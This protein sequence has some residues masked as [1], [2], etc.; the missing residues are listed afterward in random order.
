[1]IL[2]VIARFEEKAT[3]RKVSGLISK[4]TF[5]HIQAQQ[6]WS[7]AAGAPDQA[8]DWLNIWLPC[9]T[10]PS[11]FEC[12]S[13]VIHGDLHGLIAMDLRGKRVQ[14]GDAL[15]VDFLATNPQD[16]IALRGFKYIGVS[17]MAVAVARS[18]ELGMA[19]R[20]WLESLPDPR[21]LKFYESLGMTLQAER[22][23]DGFDVFVFDSG[24]ALEFLTTATNEKW[25]NISNQQ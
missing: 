25:V 14:E 24:R 22:S 13:A 4:T 15:M 5:A 2:P 20:V 7:Y 11:S 1:M 3:A 23:A 8:W 6:Q 16:R 17:L 19:G 10:M 18:V 12:C 21:T 9:Q